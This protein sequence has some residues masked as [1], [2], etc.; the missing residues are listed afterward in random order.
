MIYNLNINNILF[1]NTRLHLAAI[2]F[3]EN[4]TRQQAKNQNGDV[5]YSVSF[6][7]GRQGEGVVKEVKVKQTFSGCKLTIFIA[8]C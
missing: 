7:K 3:N 1:F 2:H 8:E 4:S 6:P 5:I